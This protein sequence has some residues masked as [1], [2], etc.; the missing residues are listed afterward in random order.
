MILEAVSTT[1]RLPV[2]T[3]MG[4]SRKAR[5]VDARVTFALIAFR[6]GY[7]YSDVAQILKRDRTTAYHYKEVGEHRLETERVFAHRCRESLRLVLRERNRMIREVSAPRIVEGF[8]LC[9]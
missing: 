3:I 6:F 8:A 2:L 1:H 4:R 7:H 9:G 5:I